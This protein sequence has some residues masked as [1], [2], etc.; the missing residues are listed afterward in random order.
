MQA[1]NILKSWR[2]LWTAGSALLT[3]IITQA[4]I[5]LTGGESHGTDRSSARQFQVCRALGWIPCRVRARAGRFNT[6]RP[7]RHE[8]T[9]E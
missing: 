1:R 8:H 9:H 5:R 4:L 2:S 6:H 3:E 7:L